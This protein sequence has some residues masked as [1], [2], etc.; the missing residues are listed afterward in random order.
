MK[1]SISVNMD[2]AAFEDEQELVT[3]LKGVIKDY[4]NGNTGKQLFDS[5]GNKVGQWVIDGDAE[6]DYPEEE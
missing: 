1:F 3:I 5:N 2:N 4:Q 6:Y